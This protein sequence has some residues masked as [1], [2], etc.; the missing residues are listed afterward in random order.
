MYSKTCLLL[1]L[2][3]ALSTGCKKAIED[4]FKGRVIDAMT[5]G[6][7]HLTKFTKGSADSTSAFAP[8]FFQFH[9]NNTVD[10]LKNG[11]IEKTGTWSA[12]VGNRTI[13]SSFGNVSTP[14]ALLNGT[15]NVTDNSWT[16]VVANQTVNGETL[17]LRLEK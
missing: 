15:W 9:E 17:N 5:T 2:C 3:G 14:L 4:I 12:D 16:H 10:A 1:L 11:A 13:T 7:W 8:Y 6:Q